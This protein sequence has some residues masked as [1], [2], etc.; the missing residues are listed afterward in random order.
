MV[1]PGTIMADHN[2]GLFSRRATEMS[3]SLLYITALQ[4]KAVLRVVIHEHLPI[5]RSLPGMP[6]SSRWMTKGP[7]APR[8]VFF[9]S[10]GC[11]AGVP[12]RA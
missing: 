11:G 9:P 7:H 1:L 8:L 10:T 12:A 6:L 5:Y 2:R 3:D 4:K